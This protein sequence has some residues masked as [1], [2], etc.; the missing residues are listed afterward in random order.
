MG[1][2]DWESQAATVSPQWYRCTA[3]LA[4][5]QPN[6]ISSRSRRGK[7]EMFSLPET[8]ECFQKKSGKNPEVTEL[9][10]TCLWLPFLPLGGLKNIIGNMLCFW[11]MWPVLVF[12]RTQLKKVLMPIDSL[13]WIDKLL[14][15][16]LEY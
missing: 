12:L 11:K 3:P 14:D 10:C 2:Q 1:C 4:C 7:S 8:I 9:T 5:K 6:I 16:D 13:F 15:W